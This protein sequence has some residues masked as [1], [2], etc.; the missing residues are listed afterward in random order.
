[1]SLLRG[2]GKY[3]MQV[4]NHGYERYFIFRR[5]LRWKNNR[6]EL[7]CRIK[8]TLYLANKEH[9]KPKVIDVEYENM[10]KA[11]QD[12]CE[13]F[14]GHGNDEYVTS[15][16]TKFSDLMNPCMYEYYKDQQA[17]ANDN[18]NG[19]GNNDGLTDEYAESLNNAS[20]ADSKICR[21]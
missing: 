14:N 8:K 15:A 5:R 4:R 18:N 6:D 20:R 16:W 17:N 21:G 2:R 3:G 7:S 19:D 1:M 9:E 11:K 10:A 13:V 12:F